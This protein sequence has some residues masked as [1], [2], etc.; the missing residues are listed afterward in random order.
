MKPNLIIEM[1]FGSHVYGTHLP[2]SDHD[3][4]G[5]FIPQAR[6]ILLQ[7]AP[8][9]INHTTRPDSEKSNRPED[10][11]TEYFSLQ[12]YLQLLLEGQ[13]IALD[14]LFTP[15][16][17]Y[18]M[19]P[20]PVWEEI[21]REKKRFLHS[22]VSAFARYCQAQAMKY[23]RKGNRI[24]ALKTVLEVL[25]KQKGEEILSEI[26]PELEKLAAMK[27]PLINLVTLSETHRDTPGRYLEV[28][29]KKV[30]FEA[31]VKFGRKVYEKALNQFGARAKSA[32]ENEGVDWK[33][34][35]HAIRVAKEGVELL[36][37]GRVTFP[38]PEKDILLSVRQGKM[39]YEK[40]IDTIEEAVA[41][42]TAAAKVSSLPA[43]P[44]RTF[45]EDLVIRV[46]K[47]IVAKS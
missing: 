32:E 8:S 42:L 38:R 12:R 34:L 16:A 27:N 36:R 22:G 18:R 11:D 37:E 33:A 43:A 5:I 15:P 7:S 23:G 40:V 17:H 1:E 35:S 14:M 28:C 20:H 3:I 44:D 6:D 26:A 41:D 31:S 24:A 46:Y 47:E 39:P 29:G 30:P 45:A 2:T 10:I 9:A 21:Q 19:K 4:K 13:T 25:E